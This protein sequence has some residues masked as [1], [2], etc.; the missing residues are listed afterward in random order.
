[1]TTALLIGRYQP[2][3]NGHLE[4]VKKILQECD[5]LVIGIG[6]AQASHSKDNP[7]TGGERI[8]MI[9]EALAEEGVPLHRYI[10]VPIQDVNNNA[11]WVSHVKAFC[12]PFDVTY[13]RNP[14]TKRLLGEAGIKVKQQPEFDR[15]KY[16]GTAIRE[17]MLAGKDWESL[18]PKGAARIIKKIGGV[19]RLKAV[20][21]TD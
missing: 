4:V 6:S 9:S 21:G 16:S 17:R 3:H 8:M 1:M 20:I 11:L 14:L 13:T 5:L 15:H 19:E 12:P 2:F 7:F 18:V 10:I